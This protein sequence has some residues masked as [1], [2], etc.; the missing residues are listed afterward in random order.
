MP[1]ME[2]I[3]ETF[4]FFSNYSS[5]VLFTAFILLLPLIGLEVATY[6]LSTSK[7]L[8]QSIFFLMLLLN[9][10]YQPIYS[11]GM[12]HYVAR[13]AHGQERSIRESFL[14]AFSNWGN[15]LAVN[16]VVLFA[17]TFGLILL[18]IPG[19]IIF[20]RLSLAEYL[21]ILNR[22]DA[23]NALFSSNLLAKP[24]TVQIINSSLILFVPYFVF[25]IWIETMGLHFFV[26]IAIS[27]VL[28]IFL[29]ALMTILL[30]RFYDLAHKTGGETPSP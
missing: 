30:F 28:S 3:R 26:F 14:V 29:L 9:I 23:R 15:L 17:T 22:Y 20:A 25:S 12:I 6:F 11:G 5:E 13:I 27:T 10:L 2:R 8:P 19:L 7:T 1:P 18:I 21:I 4:A 16:I 24:L